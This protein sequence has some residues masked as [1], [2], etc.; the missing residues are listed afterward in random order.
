MMRNEAKIWPAAPI[1]GAA[2][3]I[4]QSKSLAPRRRTYAARDMPVVTL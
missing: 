3:M 1:I 4:P 2:E